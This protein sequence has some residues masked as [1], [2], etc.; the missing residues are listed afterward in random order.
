MTYQEAI[1]FLHGL[2]QFSMRLGL[3][4]TVQLA[5]ELG[6][7]QERLRFIHVAGT[8]GKGSTC[9][10]LESMYRASGLKVGL[11]TSPHLVHFGE[12][13]QINRRL[14][15]EAAVVDLLNRIRPALTKL[16]EP[17]HPTF[18]EVVTLMALLHFADERCDVV[19]WETGLGGRLDATNIVTP[20]ASVITRIGLD[21]QQWLGDTVAKIAAEKAGIIKPAIPCVSA[22]QQPEVELVLREVCR[23]K[24]A[25]LRLLTTE[26]AESP[27]LHGVQLPLPGPHQR[28]NAS[29]AL[30]TV[31]TLNHQLPVSLAARK[32]GL[33]QTT[34]PGRFQR[35][36]SPRTIHILDGAHN[37]DGAQVLR[38]T[39]ESEYPGQQ[40]VF[41][42]GV[43]K[44]KAWETMIE[45]L[46]PLM[47]RLVLVR[48]DSN[49]TATPDELEPFCRS[50]APQLRIEKADTVAAAL[51][52]TRDAELSVIAGSLY[53]V[54]QALE[55]LQPAE[56]P[57]LPE[58]ALNEWAPK[59]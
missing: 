58:R 37:A 43:L 48:V 40:A 31:E 47:K 44:D 27:G 39:L 3:E 8:N 36:A 22:P 2:G 14:L 57:S 32:Q 4:R 56:G 51:R 55:L 19:V 7:P 18:F 59:S 33:E 23:L 10:F 9:A 20:L 29:V 21:H 46:L 16:S 30:A 15:P 50:R 11:F 12:R 26:T 17:D 42:L 24:S 35:V 53:L 5:A 41:V 54:G 49:R 25:P 1:Q 52:S 13:I 34:W 45:V 6:S 28:Q 38:D